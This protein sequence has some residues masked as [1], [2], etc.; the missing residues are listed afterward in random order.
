M[1]SERVSLLRNLADCPVTEEDAIKLFGDAEM[2][3]PE[4]LRSFLLDMCVAFNRLPIVTDECVQSA[5][6]EL[7]LDA[8]ELGTVSLMEWKSFF[9]YLLDSPL[10][11][12]EQMSFRQLKLTGATDMFVP[13]K[14][15]VITSE[16]LDDK[17]IRDK[18]ASVSATSPAHFLWASNA[19]SGKV[20]ALIVF[21]EP[22]AAEASLSL[23]N[24]QIGSSTINVCKYAPETPFPEFRQ[25]G[26]SS[27][28][29]TSMVASMLASTV[30]FGKMI[31]SQASA[32]DERLQI[33]ATAKKG[34]ETTKKAVV[35][36][37]EKIGLSKG[38]KSAAS[39]ADEKLHISDT[40]KAAKAS[41]GQAAEKVSA[42]PN[43]SATMAYVGGFFGKIKSAA[44][45][46][47]AQ[48]RAAIEQKE[49]EN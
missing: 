42:N 19:S 38:V 8:N 49:R 37:D 11:H 5:L 21:D 4:E 39:H 24:S 33:S 15:V 45:D 14:A 27:N 30:L 3:G 26:S 35:E 13:D 32:L 17:D 47:G 22:A 1:S 2:W 28:A 44:S 31:G 29:K 48:T 40:A 18:V 10:K 12:L 20:A 36:T 34:Y 43:V 25:S 23:N 7:Q 6:K 16:K 41:A 9:V 46:L